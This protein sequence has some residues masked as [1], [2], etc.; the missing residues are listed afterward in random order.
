MLAIAGQTD[1]LNFCVLKIPRATPWHF[2]KHYVLALEI[3][4]DVYNY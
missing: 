4:K 1:G 2:N 3:K